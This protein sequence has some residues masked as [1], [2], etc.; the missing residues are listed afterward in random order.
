VTD[1]PAIPLEKPVLPRLAKTFGFFIL[2]V[3]IIA[4]GWEGFRY[5]Q[6][7]LALARAHREFSNR[8]FMRAEFW[9]GR[10]FNVDEKNV[11]ATRLMAEIYEAQ[12]Q[13]V[14]LRWRILVVQRE[15]GNIDD[16]MA[17]AKSALRFAQGEMAVNALNSLPADFKNHSAEY[18]E[19]M[20]GCA[21]AGHESGIAE[22]YFAKAAELDHDNPV[23]RVNLVA[24]RLTNAP[25][26]EIRA[27][28]TRDLE[29]VLADARVNLPAARALLYDAVRSRDRAR[30]QRFAEK[31]R[32]L[33]EHNFTD[34]LSCLE[35]L[36]GEPAFRPALDEIEHRAESNALWAAEAGDWLNSHG[37]VAETLQWF[38]RL[39]EAIQTNVRVQMT[40]AEG[41]T[42]TSDWKGLQVFLTGCHWESGEYLRR[43]MVIRC[44]RELSEPWEKEWNQLAADAEA[45]PPQG[46]LLAQ[47]A[48]GW[49]WRNEALNLLWG[50]ATKP[51]TD[52]KA[53]QSLW[54]LYSQTNETDKLLRVAQAQLALEP[55]N[56]ARKNNDAFLSLLLHGAS[57]HS[58]R[59]A[60][61][62]STT[63]PNVPEWAATYAYALHLAGKDAEA[64]KVMEHLSPEALQR[65]GIALYY[66]IVLAANGDADKARESLSKLN[67]TGMLPEERK[68]AADLAL[69]LNAAAR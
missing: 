15:P 5:A 68:L 55:S 17:W 33:P 19:L 56:P 48:I 11:D 62:A 50:A 59:L 24:F 32:S 67:P 9:T 27:T 39:P 42:A 35:P 28:A 41:Y 51:Q 25:S 36:M 40:E 45:N 66:A 29:G 8:Q 16:I 46:F 49:N 1:S 63:N 10:A 54:D 4:G 23:Y 3:L 60:R 12:D 57:E 34:D 69:Q 37:M 13:P 14:A 20:A 44:K 26:Q 30:A 64:K 21:L 18:H 31:L 7:H 43:A 2:A 22:A 65:P 6:L 47:L 53:L 58:E 38:P 61:E 52:S